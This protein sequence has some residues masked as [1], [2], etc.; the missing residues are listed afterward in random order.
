MARP[1][2]QSA[3]S[4]PVFGSRARAHDPPPRPT[5]A[6]RFR[7]CIDDTL[8]A[9]AAEHVFTLSHARLLIRLVDADANKRLDRA[10]FRLL[11]R[12]VS[13]W[14]QFFLA[15]SQAHPVHGPTMPLTTFS[16]YLRQQLQAFRQPG[17]GADEQHVRA[18]IGSIT[19]LICESVAG[20]RPDFVI[21]SDY[22]SVQA[23]LALVGRWKYEALG[24]TM[25]DMVR[26]SFYVRG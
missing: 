17:D 4:L 24:L 25:L 5:A 7:A 14:S 20:K 22:Y 26:F 19:D 18:K 6:G 11:W 13:Q 3:P 15:H 1:A 10:E 2:R 12:T 16:L 9:T 8:H 23:S 21:M